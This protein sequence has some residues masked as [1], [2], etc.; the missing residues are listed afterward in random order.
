[1]ATN[2]NISR[3]SVLLGFQILDFIATNHHYSSEASEVFRDQLSH[4]TRNHF[5]PPSLPS[6]TTART[7]FG[8][9]EEPS[10]TTFPSDWSLD[11]SL[12]RAAVK[13][14]KNSAGIIEEPKKSTRSIS[15]SF[16]LPG[17]PKIRL[18]HKSTSSQSPTK[19]ANT[20]DNSSNTQPTQ[21]TPS[22][23][24]T[25]TTA[26]LNAAM[27]QFTQFRTSMQQQ[28]QQL[29]QQIAT[30][31][32]QQQQGQQPSMPPIF[33][34]D[35]NNG[36]NGYVPGKTNKEW[37][38]DDIGYFDPEFEGEGPVVSSG[39]S[40]YYRDVYAFVE[41]LKDMLPIRGV[42]KLRTVI[43]QC[44]RGSALIWYSTELT[45]RDKRLYRTAPIEEWHDLLITRFKERTPLA[46]IKMQAARYT[47]TDAKARKD[48]RAYVQDFTRFPRAANLTSVHNQLSM[49][50]NNLDWEFRLH[51]PEPTSDTSLQQF[52]ENLL[53]LRRICGTKWPNIGDPPKIRSEGINSNLSPINMI[54]INEG[55]VP[56]RESQRT[57]M[58]FP[59]L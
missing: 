6:I 36:G 27:N 45:E 8:I 21:P 24:E 41:R 53:T 9:V 29:Q 39:K 34:P 49:A 26:Q 13:S 33:P 52:L 42:D 35:G 56:A 32:A 18:P 58:Q 28:F 12:F 15:P 47:M 48:P 3:E 37:N 11:R 5:R 54:N 4:F 14:F 43:P 16:S 10:S 31:L 38:T 40:V 46:L 30:S 7:R 57:E 20:G 23:Q 22:Q 17:T 1:M 50:W 55:V 19:M 2:T 44:L 59:A 51:I 25:N